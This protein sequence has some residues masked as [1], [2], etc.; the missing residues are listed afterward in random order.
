MCKIYTVNSDL[1]TASHVAKFKIHTHFKLSW[2]GDYVIILSSRLFTAHIT[3]CAYLPKYLSVFFRV[4]CCIYNERPAVTY[5]KHLLCFRRINV[6]Y[7]NWILGYI[8]RMLNVRRSLV[9][10]RR[11]SIPLFT[12]L[13]PSN[14]KLTP[15]FPPTAST[16]AI[17]LRDW[18]FVYHWENWRQRSKQHALNQIRAEIGERAR[19]IHHVIRSQRWVLLLNLE[20]GRNSRVPQKNIVILVMI[21]SFGKCIFACAIVTHRKQLIP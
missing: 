19:L 14:L 21:P 10:R 8:S 15:T 4:I 5:R 12:T 11:I 6:I 2:Y 20:L 9:K 1:S 3:Y 17:W 7:S 16:L 18:H 13:L